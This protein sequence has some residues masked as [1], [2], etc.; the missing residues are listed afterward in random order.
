MEAFDS[1][2]QEGSTL[3]F[4]KSQWTNFSKMHAQAKDF[5]KFLTTLERQFKSI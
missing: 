1:I 3:E 2:N 5:V 4:Y